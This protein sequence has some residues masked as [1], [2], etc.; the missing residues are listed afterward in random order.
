MTE[1][2]AAWGPIDRP[3]NTPPPMTALPQRMVRAALLA[4]T[5]MSKL[6]FI[7]RRN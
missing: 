7:G 4:S 5:A 6:N 1:Q 3:S 2:S